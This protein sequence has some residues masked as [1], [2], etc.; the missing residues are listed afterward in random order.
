M[1][2]K[3]KILFIHVV[4]FFLKGGAHAPVAPPLATALTLHNSRPPLSTKP[5]LFV[6]FQRDNQSPSLKHLI[7]IEYRNYSCK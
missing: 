7:S 6:E 4:I 2:S 5:G 1:K 3:I